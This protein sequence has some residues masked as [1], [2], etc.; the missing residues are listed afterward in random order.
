[1]FSM[2][3]KYS[4]DVF[5]QSQENNVG[6]IGINC[7]GTH[8]FT[9]KIFDFPMRTLLC[10]SLT[11]APTSTVDQDPRFPEEVLPRP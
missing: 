10:Q 9:D 11:V 1:M 6:V 8:H 5:H 4:D 7:H 3:P 2:V